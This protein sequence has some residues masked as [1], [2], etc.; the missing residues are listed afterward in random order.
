MNV[1][2]HVKYSLLFSYFNETWILSADFRK[3]LKYEIPWKS[4]Q[5]EPSYMRMD[6]QAGRQTD[7]HDEANS[8]LWQFCE[9]AEKRGGESNRLRIIS[10][11]EVFCL[12]WETWW[13]TFYPVPQHGSCHGMPRR[14]QTVYALKLPCLLAWLTLWPWNWTFK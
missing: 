7:R 11:W 9:R 6:G 12:T 10:S 13:C 3:I 2:L 14:I 5:W 8:R 1:G 4:F